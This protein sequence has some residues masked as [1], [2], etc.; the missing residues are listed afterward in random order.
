MRQKEEEV[1]LTTWLLAMG[2]TNVPLLRNLQNEEF[3]NLYCSADIVK[4]IWAG[5]VA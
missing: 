1:Y 3:C 2:Q 4:V 5:H